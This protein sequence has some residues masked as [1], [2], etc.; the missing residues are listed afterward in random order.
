MMGFNIF[1]DVTEP[2]IWLFKTEAVWI[3]YRRSLCD[4]SLEVRVGSEV[5]VSRGDRHKLLNDFTR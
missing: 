1:K 3:S 5:L 4:N 2:S